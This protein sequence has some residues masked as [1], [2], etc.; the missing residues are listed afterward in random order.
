VPRCSCPGAKEASRRP[1]RAPW[2]ALGLGRDR[3]ASWRPDSLSGPLWR[4]L[5]GWIDKLNS[6]RRSGESYSEAIIRL[7][8]LWEG[9][10]TQKQR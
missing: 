1:Q 7:A 2:T 4:I 5:P 10:S 3:K 9:H 6:I 8:A